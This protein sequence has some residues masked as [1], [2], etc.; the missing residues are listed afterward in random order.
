MER[1]GLAFESALRVLQAQLVVAPARA[2][3]AELRIQVEQDRAV[4]P[5]VERRLLVEQ[6]DVVEVESAG[7]SLV[8]QR[9]VEVTV[10]QDVRAGGERRLDELPQVLRAVGDVE[11]ELGD[12]VDPRDLPPQ[13]EASEAPPQR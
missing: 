3:E 2:V 9:R 1:D 12:R 7:E 4:G 5:A 8:G 13:Q 6:P 11:A 10:A